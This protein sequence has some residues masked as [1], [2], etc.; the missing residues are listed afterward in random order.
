MRLLR[1]PWWGYV[2]L[3]NAFF[4]G[5]TAAFPYARHEFW[6]WNILNHFNLA[7]EM[8]IA[9]WWSTALL[10]VAGLLACLLAALGEKLRYSWCTL[11][12][13]FA[14]LSLD[15]LGSLHERAAQTVAGTALL[16]LSGMIGALAAAHAL[17]R[18]W[19]HGRRQTAILLLAGMGLMA[20][21]AL[22][23]Y[24]E[25]RIDWPSALLGI[26]VAFEEGSEITGMLLCQIGLARALPAV[27][28]P[29]RPDWLLA[30]ANALPQLITIAGAG[31]IA[32]N[33]LSVW[34]VEYMVLEFRGNPGV[35]YFC[36]IFLTLG[37]T[38]LWRGWHTPERGQQR[39]QLILAAYFLALSVGGVYFI[40]P[41]F[42]SIIHRLGAWSDLSILLGMQLPLFA[43]ALYLL[44]EHMPWSPT[45]ALVILALVLGASWAY[46]GAFAGYLAVG[47]FAFTAVILFGSL[48][49]SYQTPRA[50]RLQLQPVDYP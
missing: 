6:R 36:A 48:W 42:N 7:G 9:A 2:L 32:H 28:S 38:F 29:K 50:G 22:H 12:L 45:P 26:R 1:A 15:E 41:R 30:G 5:V 11:A 20:S 16:A 39:V 23:E 34:A 24:F 18:L 47:W 17:W 46:S 49:L 21:A 33:L 10:L 44:R 8:T 25:H 13:L 4:M 35:W 19:N 37:T 31:F 40:T 43:L 14:L 27:P 3:I